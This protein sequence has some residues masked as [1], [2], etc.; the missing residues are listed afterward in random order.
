[1]T[2]V[3]A[4]AALE[5]R[6]IML[7]PSSADGAVARQV[8]VAAGIET[9]LCSTAQTFC[10]TAQA[11]GAVLVLAEEALKGMDFA[12]V[13]DFL[14][15]QEAWSDIPLIVLTTRHRE[16]TTRWRAIAGAVLD[17]QRHVAGAADADRDAP[18]GSPGGAA[19]PRTSVSAAWPHRG[20]GK[21]ADAKG[22]AAARG[23]PSGQEQPADDAEPGA[24]VRGAC[25]TAG[26][27]AV[28]RPGQPNWGHR[29][30]AQPD[31]RQR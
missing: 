26:S 7:P 18:A 11:G 28:R 31:L 13:L 4:G 14:D 8:L 16:P 27:T 17:R 2:A 24:P 12:C 10:A 30:V 29:A 21:P 22:G 9:A 5:Q 19:R 20:T 3:P 25:T 15:H 6:V 1:M 23:V